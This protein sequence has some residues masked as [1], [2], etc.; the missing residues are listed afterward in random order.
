M[1]ITTAAVLAG[2][3]VV[4]A[5]GVGASAQQQAE[6]GRRAENRAKGLARTERSRQAEI[7]STQEAKEREQSAT[8]LKQ[9]R[10]AARGE[11]GRRSLTAGS[12]LG[13]QST[14]G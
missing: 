7:K 1:A 8:L 2:A 13:V 3:A 11:T 10:R 6:S 12:E 9:Q 5:V 4:G 14:L